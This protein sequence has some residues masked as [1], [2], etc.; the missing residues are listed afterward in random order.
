MSGNSLTTSN[1]FSHPDTVHVTNRQIGGGSSFSL[2]LPEHS[3]SVIT[4]EVER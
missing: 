4:L 1:D 3:A 2:T